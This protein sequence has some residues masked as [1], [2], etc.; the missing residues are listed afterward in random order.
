MARS[1]L[2][3]AQQARA[4]V[5]QRLRE[6]MDDAGISAREVA[7]RCNWHESKSSRLLSG[8]TPPSES[9]IRLWCVACGA[10]SQAGGLADR[11]TSPGSAPSPSRLPC[12]RAA[13]PSCSYLPCQFV[14]VMGPQHRS[15]HPRPS[16]RPQC[17]SSS[18][19]V[20]AHS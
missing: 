20:E 9:D 15:R 7:Q 12:W 8:T 14:P 4:V 16:H 19:E 5:A 10:E 17:P 6:L 2:S 3:S 1:P 11:Q 18:S 13:P